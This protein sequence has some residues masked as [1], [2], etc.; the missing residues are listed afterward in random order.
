MNTVF[1][2]EQRG[3][4]LSRSTT[5]YNLVFQNMC[6][7]AFT[8]GCYFILIS[9]TPFIHGVLINMYTEILGNK[10]KEDLNSLMEWSS[11]V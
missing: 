10:M 11:L 3:F 9:R 5:I 8:G 7:N 4:C 2:K 6:F 1:M